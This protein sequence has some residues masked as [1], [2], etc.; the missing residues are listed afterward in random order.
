ML[1]EIVIS[2]ALTIV[3]G[4]FGA[5]ALAIVLL[6][7][8]VRSGKPACEDFEEHATEMFKEVKAR[9]PRLR[10]TNIHFKVKETV[11]LPGAG[12][13][14][15]VY[16]RHIAAGF[17][18]RRLHAIEIAE[19]THHDDHKLYDTITHEL[20]HALDTTRRGHSGHDDKFRDCQEEIEDYAPKSE[21]I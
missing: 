2:L 1:Q 19:K 3:I 21:I 15:T 7:V 10:K 20:A 5:I 6:V 13:N 18:T 8:N 17:R 14:S 4:I 12:S 11:S 16:G 9:H